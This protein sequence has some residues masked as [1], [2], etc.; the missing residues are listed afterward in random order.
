MPHLR[1][2]HL[3]PRIQTLMNFSPI[4]G[5]LGHRQVGKTTLMESIVRNYLTFDDED[6]LIEA[7]KSPKLFL[8][9]LVGL[10]IGIDEC[11][12]CE[13][14]FP[15][16]KER[17]R[18][19]KRPGQFLLSGSVR[20]TA[21]SAIKESLTGR[22]MTLDLF[23]LTLA[24]LYSRPLSSFWKHALFATKIDENSFNR[25]NPSSTQSQVDKYCVTGGL[26]G[27]CFLRKENIRRQKLT[28]YSE[29][30][31]DRDIRRIVPTTL[32]YPQ[33][34]T[35][36]REVA[37]H[38]GMPLNLS[39]MAKKT[40]ISVPTI[41]KLLFAFEAVFLIRSIPVEGDFGDVIY[42]FEDVCEAN[43]L[44]GGQLSLDSKII[45][46]LYQEIRAALCY[47]DLDHPV[48][49]FQYRTRAGVLIPIVVESDG[50]VLGVIP[51]DG[52]RPT[53]K[54]NA[55]GD[56]LLKRYAR[57]KVVFVSTTGKPIV[58]NDRSSVVPLCQT[59]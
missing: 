12:L 1:A 28:S 55:A 51:I 49:F 16:L 58:I 30:I 17:A 52:N 35:L 10:G 50:H 14:L 56:S 33:I 11:H 25:L 27:I 42:Y 13:N 18:K 38:H 7:Q 45:Q 26:P 3:T 6:T 54:E 37:L 53:R 40:G 5:I 32:A 46:V 34:L 23:P 31:L 22:I 36:L 9:N 20:F 24:E 19:D 43:H 41:K 57:S 29:T 48:R 59:F 8:K 44:T 47:A 2:R 15:A 21:K 39:Q 4:V